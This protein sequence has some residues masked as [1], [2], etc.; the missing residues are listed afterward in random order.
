M[1]C[2][3]LVINP[4]NYTEEENAANNN[5]R[6][7]YG[8]EIL[9][10]FIGTDQ[11]IHARLDKYYEELKEESERLCELSDLQ[12]R[13]TL[14]RCS[15]ILKPQ[16]MFRT[17]P[18]QIVALF[19][20]KINVLNKSI[21]CSIIG[22]P[23]VELSD[24]LYD[25]MK[26]SIKKGGL[27]ITD[28]SVLSK[29]AFVASIIDFRR[30][31]IDREDLF[32]GMLNAIEGH[33]LHSF[34]SAARFFIP[35]DANIETI[36]NVATDPD[37]TTQAQ[38]TK[39]LQDQR[40]HTVDVLLKEQ[41]PQLHYWREGLLNDA[42]GKFIEALPT[43]S[44]LKMS[45]KAYSRAIRYRYQLIVEDLLAGRRCVC[46]QRP[47]LDIGGNHLAH[48]CNVKGCNNRTHDGLK[49]TMKGIISSGGSW[50]T[51]EERNL[52]AGSD[53]R[54]DI[55]IYNHNGGG[56]RLLLDTSCTTTMHVNRAGEINLP[57]NAV[58]IGQAA[59]AMFTKKNR[60]YLTL[61]NDNGFGFLPIVFETNGFMHEAVCKLLQDTSKRA[62]EISSIP[63]GT[64]YNYYL[65]LLSVSL[66]KGLADSITTKLS[67]VI[68][69]NGRIRDH[70]LDDDEIRMAEYDVM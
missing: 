41:N 20:D 4:N 44:Q 15:F 10:S 37:F 29:S 36:F 8:I 62:S 66:Q 38:L 18:P 13:M 32:V 39:F 63:A 33:H 2:V 5:Y 47:V 57:N 68:R 21:I 25:M 56:Q 3:V 43:N 11:F 6:Q 7:E 54:P 12:E 26:F 67:H 16:H 30:D 59:Q 69:G 24:L 40:W 46:T 35:E 19:A 23:S 34:Q 64:L 22:Y 50:T 31:N 9:G 14:F 70:A 42:A 49:H 58:N 1:V 53:K 48:G 60:D 17:I 45:S 65:K 55:T 27:G 52:F 28:S 51:L 61:C